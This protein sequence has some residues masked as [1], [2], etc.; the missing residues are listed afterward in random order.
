MIVA[1]SNSE[2]IPIEKETDIVTARQV[3]RNMSRQ[4]GFGT[5]MQ[6]RIATSISELA[7]NIYL[8]AGT[9]TITIETVENDEKTGLKIT[10]LD[11]GPGIADLRKALEDGFTTSGALG[12]GLPG[13]RRM[14]DDFQ[15]E[16]T[17]GKGT[18]VVVIK[19]R[20]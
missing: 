14:M 12:A 17:L 9:G 7:R 2:T 5:I 20:E 3:G 6:S 18:R 11:E 4:L 19:W 10:A 8:Y 15:M 1:A 13:V 16:S